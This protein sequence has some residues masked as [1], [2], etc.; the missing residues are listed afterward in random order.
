MAD[1]FLQYLSLMRRK[2]LSVI[3]EMIYLMT[4]LIRIRHKLGASPPQMR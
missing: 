1:G 4:V 3:G 2:K